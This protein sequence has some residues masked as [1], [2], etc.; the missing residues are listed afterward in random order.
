MIKQSSQVAAVQIKLPPFLPREPNLW[1]A[2]INSQFATCRITTSGTKFDYAVSSLFPE[3][4]TEVQD[5]LLH[6]PEETPYEVLKAE[7]TKWT[8]ASEQ[9]HIQE[10][11]SAEELG[12][13]TPSQVLRRIQ[14][15]LGNMA[16]MVDP[17]LLRELFLQHLPSI[18]RMVITL[19][20]GALNLDQL[21][22]IAD[23]IPYFF[24]IRLLV[25]FY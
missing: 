8:S 23:C 12:N 21:A 20:A 17:T 4:A 16:G 22:Q 9:C 1:F 25:M 14:Q 5:L 18:A 7:L 11:L 19:S 6:P 24:G 10:L 15:L 2:Q 3:F 13:R